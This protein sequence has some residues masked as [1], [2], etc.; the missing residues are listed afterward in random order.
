MKNSFNLG[1]SF[2]EIGFR[3]LFLRSES[4]Q[5]ENLRRLEYSST[6]SKKELTTLHVL[7]AVAYSRTPPPNNSLR[8]VDHD[9]RRRH[10]RGLLRYGSVVQR[11]VLKKEQVSQ[12]EISV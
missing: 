12:R 2:K 7:A 6:Y 5:V 8:L 3:G 4:F 1:S 9:S 11:G 10:S